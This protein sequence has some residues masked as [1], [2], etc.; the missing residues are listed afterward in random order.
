MFK[1][2]YIQCRHTKNTYTRQVKKLHVKSTT[3]TTTAMAYCGIKAEL[4]LYT[5]KY[6]YT[7]TGLGYS[8]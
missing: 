6:M 4:G 5:V 8:S 7:E 3:E 1:W 2:S